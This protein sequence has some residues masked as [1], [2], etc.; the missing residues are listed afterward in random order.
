TKGL[1]TGS[2]TR[3]LTTD[4]WITTLTAYDKKGRAVYTA[5]KNPYLG[6]TDITES[7]LD[8]AGKVLE[9]KT[10]HTKGSS[11]AIVTVDRFGYDHRGRL[12][13]QE[14]TLGGSTELIAGNTYD[15][16]GQLKVKK[17]GNTES[18]P[19]QTVDYTYNV[20][21]WLKQINDI[22]NLGSD[23]FTFKLN[24]NTKE[25]GSGNA[26]L[27]NGN[28]SETIWKT[29]NDAADG[30]KTRGYAYQ[31]DALNR[32]TYADYGIKTTGGYNRSSGYDISVGAYDKNG[33]IT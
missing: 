31:Y 13:K 33:N 3:V 25:I 22:N 14:Q 9:T 11:P 10:T 32:I 21:G 18:N 20:R 17:V 30:N 5:T 7:K 12:L 8:F 15:D 1:A 19:L 29:A 6:T 2:K 26:L 24:Y 23:L 28:I 4:Q 16:L 27:F